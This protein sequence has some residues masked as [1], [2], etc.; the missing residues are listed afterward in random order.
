MTELGAVYRWVR[1]PG[2][3]LRSP[4]ERPV[5]YPLQF[6]P[7]MKGGTLMSLHL[8]LL[9]FIFSSQ[10]KAATGASSLVDSVKKN[11]SSGTSQG[12]GSEPACD[13]DANRRARILTLAKALDDRYEAIKKVTLATATLANQNTTYFQVGQ[14]TFREDK[15]G[16]TIPKNIETH[17]FSWDLAYQRYLELQYSPIDEKWALLNRDVN[18]LIRED[19]KR[20]VNNLNL[21]IPYWAGPVMAKAMS[22]LESCLQTVNCN[23]PQFDQQASQFVQSNTIYNSFSHLINAVSDTQKRINLLQQFRN[24]MKADFD[25]NFGF[26]ANPAVRRT[27]LNEFEVSLDAGSLRGN[28]PQLENMI[29]YV[30]SSD[31]YSLKIK[32]VDASQVPGAYKIVYQAI[33]GGDPEADRSRKIINLVQGNRFRALAHEV[34]HALGFQDHFYNNWSPG[35][36]QYTTEYFPGDIMSE[37]KTGK[38]TSTEWQTLDVNYSSSGNSTAAQASAQVSVQALGQGESLTR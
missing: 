22:D 19:K 10:V 6:L 7:C 26:T 14:A 3:L 35:S 8:A 20:L 29:K 2:G 31:Q 33:N 4:A 1:A 17:T 21:E 23:A 24:R 34:G 28:E 32:W 36:C 27:G 37:D 11:W 15:P 5:A 38:A 25:Y 13:T 18:T 30:W 16:N 12:L 9:T